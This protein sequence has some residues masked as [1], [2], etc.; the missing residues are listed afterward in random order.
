MQ[1]ESSDTQVVSVLAE[2][3]NNQDEMET[4]I[5]QQLLDSLAEST[6]HAAEL[7]ATGFSSAEEPRLCSPSLPSLVV[8]GGGSIMANGHDHFQPVCASDDRA[9]EARHVE[10]SALGSVEEGVVAACSRGQAWAKRPA[11]LGTSK[12]CTTND[13]ALQSE[14]QTAEATRQQHLQSIDECQA[15]L[16]ASTKA[17]LALTAA[18]R[19]KQA[20][21]DVLEGGLASNAVEL[22]LVGRIFYTSLVVKSQRY[23]VGD[24]LYFS[25][26]EGPRENTIVVPPVQE[27]KAAAGDPQVSLE[28]V[29]LLRRTRII[30]RVEEVSRCLTVGHNFGANTLL[31]CRCGGIYSR[32]HGFRAMP[33]SS[34]IKH[35]AS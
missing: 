2:D 28:E 31:G 6:G 18:L 26:E 35:I 27:G 17:V 33:I 12:A 9:S 3:E 10:D 13:E 25:R 21:L 30:V 15:G 23:G 7:E 16:M 20:A 19:R 5:R 29:P 1:A 22:G 14:L 24:C 8:N 34:H 4:D 32:D 11:L